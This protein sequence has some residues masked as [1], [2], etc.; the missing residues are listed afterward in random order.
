MERLAVSATEIALLTFKEGVETRRPV[1]ALG[2]QPHDQ[3]CYNSH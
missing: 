3:K 1:E 2:G